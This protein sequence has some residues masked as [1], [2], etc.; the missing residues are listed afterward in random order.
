[1]LMVIYLT[2]RLKCLYGADTVDILAVLLLMGIWL[3]VPIISCVPWRE[4]PFWGICTI[5]V[6]SH[7]FN[8]DMIWYDAVSCCISPSPARDALYKPYEI[9]HGYFPTLSCQGSLSKIDL[10]LCYCNILSP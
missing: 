3:S 6:Y 8:L 5:H 2:N 9:T 7:G 4:L 1:M 10:P